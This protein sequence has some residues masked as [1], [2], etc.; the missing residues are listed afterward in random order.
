[1]KKNIHIEDIVVFLTNTLGCFV[2]S[3]FFISSKNI[4]EI[5]IGVYLIFNILCFYSV[6]TKQL[7]DKE[8]LEEQLRRLK[9]E[10]I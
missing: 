1:M 3:A 9:N 4:I 5:C 10:K 6:V 2:L 7:S 8:Y